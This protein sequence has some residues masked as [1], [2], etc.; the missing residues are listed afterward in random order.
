M[1]TK[2]AR[3]RQE[4]SGLLSWTP[5]RFRQIDVPTQGTLQ[6]TKVNFASLLAETKEK[7]IALETAPLF[8]TV[9]RLYVFQ[10][11]MATP[12]LFSPTT[13]RPPSP[14]RLLTRYSK[15][16]KFTTNKFT[17]NKIDLCRLK[18][19]LSKDETRRDGSNPLIVIKSLLIL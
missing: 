1:Q 18:S 13:Y 7:K 12:K 9:S 5:Q 16:S 14:S 19:P 4:S 8:F 2:F 10:F 11:N 3:F 6:A 15:P 17:F